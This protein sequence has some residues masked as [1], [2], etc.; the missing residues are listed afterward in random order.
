MELILIR[1]GKTAG[2]IRKAYIGSTDEPL[3][4]EGI[5]ELRSRTPDT[6]LGHVYVTSLK[7]TQQ[8][9][10]YLFPNAEQEILPE[11]REM[12]FGVFENRTADEMRDDAE[13]TDW[14]NAGCVPQC[15][16]GESMSSFAERVGSGMTSLLK[17]A[18]E[19]SGPVV[20]VTHGGVIMALMS[21][22]DEKGG[23]YYSY[24]VDNL[25]GYAVTTSIGE[26]GRPVFRNSRL[27]HAGTNGPE[28][29]A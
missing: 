21:S 23:D 27:F 8:T 3:S 17:R 25:D 5:S 14:V 28:A 29:R 7:R 10:R 4:G 1:H 22:F 16:N 19:G 6:T 2:N 12:D 9:A 24:W 15:R 11:L 20:L 18:G 26:D 13:Y